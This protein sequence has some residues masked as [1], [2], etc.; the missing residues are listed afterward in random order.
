[1][2]SF[3]TPCLRWKLVMAVKGQYG[4]PGFIAPYATRY[5]TKLVVISQ[6]PTL[7]GPTTVRQQ[8]WQ[9]DRIT[10]A[11]IFPADPSASQAAADFPY[12]DPLPEDPVHSETWS[13][14]ETN[15]KHS[16]NNG[17]FV[18]ETEVTL[19]DPY[20]L[21]TLD[22]DTDALLNSVSI[23][24]M[25]W[26][27]IQTVRADEV[28][29]T[30]GPYTPTGDLTVLLPPQVTYANIYSGSP[31][32]A[33]Q[34]N[35]AAWSVYAPGFVFDDNWYPNGYSKL[36]GHIAMAGNYCQKI[37]TIDYNQN[38]LNEQCVSGTGSCSS[39][40]KVSSP[41]EITPGQNSYVLIQPNCQCGT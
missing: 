41:I 9:L 29:F 30:L 20:D 35:A 28:S 34:L 32:P 13:V 39:A 8:L 25:P 1:M 18:I 27:T 40:F 22:A 6:T 10:G 37:F 16:Y 15:F 31:A 23:A 38:L 14:S 21:A 5:L 33:P 12:G 3:S 11:I 2:F 7:G 19:S 24:S 4:W 17:A 36:I 26:N